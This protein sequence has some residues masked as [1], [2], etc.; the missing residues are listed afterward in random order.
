MKYHRPASQLIDIRRLRQPVAI[1]AQRRL[2]IIHADQKNIPRL[3][4]RCCGRRPRKQKNAE[5]NNSDAPPRHD[6]SSIL[7]E[8]N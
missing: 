8:K 2:E 1:T 4:T 3:L 7:F 5:K 6:G